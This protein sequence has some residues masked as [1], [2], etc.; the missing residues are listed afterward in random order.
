MAVQ[1]FPKKWAILIGVNEYEHVTPL[2]FCRQDALDLGDMFRNTLGFEK[3][4]ILTFVEESE[5]L[6]QRARIFHYLGQ[7]KETKN[8]GENDLLVFFFSGHG[9]IGKDDSKDY[10]LP[11][12]ATPL[13]LRHT[14]IRIE[15]IAEELKGTGC[16]N[17]VMFIDACR[18]LI[19]GAKSI[20]S[21]GDDSVEALKRA[22]IVTFFS[23]K[24]KDKSYEIEHLKHGAFT[25]CIL[26]AI[27]KG[28]GKTVSSL[29][30][31]LR[32]QVPLINET[33]KKPPQQPYAIIEPAEKRD[34]QI[35][36]SMAQQKQM[37]A[38]LDYLLQ[39]IGDLYDE[40][41]LDDEYLN[42][43]ADFLSE[44]KEKGS[45]EQET[46]R[47]ILIQKLCLGPLKITAFKVAWE[48]HERRKISPTAQT[49]LGRLT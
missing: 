27:T 29:E 14:G 42:K 46:K 7:I 17:I 24:P 26:E 48:A 28:E 3:D 39:R 22:G 10:L 31:Y 35:F 12:D 38:D 20:V 47:I 43:A 9:M 8:V 49:S 36:F 19:A 23:C 11:I 16:K 45:V 21:I 1:P 6:P 44:V 2:Q 41:K 18:E 30:S 40:G 25:H 15:D 37:E 4:D 32:K 34:L 33:Y 5:Y 13:N